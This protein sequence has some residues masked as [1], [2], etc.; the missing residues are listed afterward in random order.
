M[1]RKI[2]QIT[3]SLTFATALATGCSDSSDEHDAG[4]AGGEHHGGAED[5]ECQA[6]SSV[7]HDVDAASK[8]AGDCHELAHENDAAVCTANKAR[9][10]ALCEA[11][12]G[13]G[14]AGGAGGAR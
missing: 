14:G 6:I 12:T 9:C 4:G 7:C 2:L 5:P 10:I 11:L 8:D 3:C 13:G 1:F